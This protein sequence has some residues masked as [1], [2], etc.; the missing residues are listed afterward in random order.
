MATTTTEK[1]LNRKIEEISFSFLCFSFFSCCRYFLSGRFY[2]SKAWRTHVDLLECPWVILCNTVFQCHLIAGHTT[3]GPIE[4][5]TDSSI[6]ISRIELLKTIVQWSIA[7]LNGI[8]RM[9]DVKYQI[10]ILHEHWTCIIIRKI[11]KHKQFCCAMLGCVFF[12]LSKNI[13]KSKR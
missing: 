2:C 6:N 7:L 8:H 11:N 1:K 3:N 9:R 4:A 12:S 10:I 5:I 13:F